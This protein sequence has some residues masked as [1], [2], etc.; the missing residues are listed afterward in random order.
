MSG[1]PLI[2]VVIP[3]Y[4]AESTLAGAVESALSQ[5]GPEV[6]VIIVDDG[7][8]DRS[9]AIAQAMEDGRKVR[10]FTTGRNSGSN[11]AM[12]TGIAQMRGTYFAILD[13]D[14]YYLPGK[15]AKQ[16]D[17]LDTD[18]AVSAVF[19]LPVFVNEN[20]EEID[21]PRIRE[22]LLTGN[23][24]RLTWAA[25]LFYEGGFLLSASLLLRR[26]AFDRVGL[27]DPRFFRQP[28]I[29]F[30]VRLLMSENIHILE[31]RLY[32]YRRNNRGEHNSNPG[33]AADIHRSLDYFSRHEGFLRLTSV[34]DV[35][36]MF[37][38]MEEEFPGLRDKKD[39]LGETAAQGLVGLAAVISDWPMTAA[40]GLQTLSRLMADPAKRS[41]LENCLG[42]T[43]E[44]LQKLMAATPVFEF[45][46]IPRASR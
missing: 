31:E 14:D 25:H 37:P 30:H 7:S 6:E 33:R 19:C 23:R 5:E 17:I 41:S 28:D 40:F 43:P 18:P 15:L 35:L 36:E 1:G 20:G 4:N 46:Q 44:T 8:Q 11:T 2:S 38:F 22:G 10:V 34:E 24:S 12:N 9:L 27:F 45:P 32:A 13:A 26:D 29:E 21:F 42:I 39:L 16:L 3:V